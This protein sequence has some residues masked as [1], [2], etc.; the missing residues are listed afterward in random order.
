MKGLVSTF[1]IRPQSYQR[2]SK[3]TCAICGVIV[4]IGAAEGIRTLDK[5]I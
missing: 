5:G 1:D 2:N 4:F 3:K